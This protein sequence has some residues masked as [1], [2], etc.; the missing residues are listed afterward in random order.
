VT[1]WIEMRLR[2]LCC[3]SNILMYENY[4]E[5]YKE[6]AYYKSQQNC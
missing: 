6:V 1:V 2:S 4:S 3:K 5:K